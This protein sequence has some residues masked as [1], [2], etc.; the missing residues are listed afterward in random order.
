[1]S[2][3]DDNES[4]DESEELPWANS[5]K[6]SGAANSTNPTN[7]PAH[8]PVAVNAMLSA[9]NSGHKSIPC[10]AANCDLEK[11]IK[12]PVF[13][14]KLVPLKVREQNRAMNVINHAIEVLE[15]DPQDQQHQ[16]LV[17]FDVLRCC[18]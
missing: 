16:L 18:V 2:C 7:K 13:K 8:D 6:K 4:G 17:R 9:L 12:L 3:S 10:P 1:M 14:N 11:G 5:T 15:A